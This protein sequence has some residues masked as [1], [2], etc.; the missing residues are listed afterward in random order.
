M[1]L[2]STS[3]TFPHALLFE[4]ERNVCREHIRDFIEKKLGIATAQNPDVFFHEYDRFFVADVPK[5]MAQL[6]QKPLGS[7]QVCVLLF[8]RMIWEAQSKL[9]KSIEEPAPNTFIILATPMPSELLDTVRSRLF[10]VARVAGDGEKSE[11]VQAF[12]RGSVAER[13]EIIEKFLKDRGEARQFVDAL[14]EFLVTD[15]VYKNAEALREVAFVQ[16]YLR[17]PSSGVK[18]LLEYLVLWIPRIG[19]RK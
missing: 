4:G 16:N 13:N 19:G 14:E 8:E 12:L 2:S 17:D 9:L 11:Q 6:S 3:T 1:P 15:G 18:M 7:A 5:V 10:F